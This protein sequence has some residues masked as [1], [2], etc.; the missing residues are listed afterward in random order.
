MFPIM[1]CRPVRTAAFDIMTSVPR[2]NAK[3]TTDN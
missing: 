1:K 3:R 2:A